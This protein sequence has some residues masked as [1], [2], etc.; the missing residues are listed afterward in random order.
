ML[1]MPQ[2]FA[3]R[4]LLATLMIPGGGSC[5]ANKP[6]YMLRISLFIVSLS[7]FESKLSRCPC[8]QQTPGVS[9]GFVCFA[10]RGGFEPP[11]P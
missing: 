3:E 6:W 10:E 2:R 8:K 1:K 7:T 4:G 11:V 5:K 9:R